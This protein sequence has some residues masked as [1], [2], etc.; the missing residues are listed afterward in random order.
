MTGLP[1]GTRFRITRPGVH[2]SVG[3]PP[4]SAPRRSCVVN[5]SVCV[6]VKSMSVCVLVS[7]YM[8]I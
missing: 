5:V 1:G 2:M 3:L 4:S 7:V 8:C 6:C